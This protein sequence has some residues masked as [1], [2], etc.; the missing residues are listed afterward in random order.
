MA[1]VL[2]V[3]LLE[4]GLEAVP[5]VSWGLRLRVS[6]LAT[7]G[8]GLDRVQRSHYYPLRPGAGP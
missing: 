6:G 2:V 1:P 3:L 4:A 7:A 5:E 8:V